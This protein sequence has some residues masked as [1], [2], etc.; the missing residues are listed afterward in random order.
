MERPGMKRLSA[1]HLDFA[2][3]PTFLPRWS[4]ALLSAGLLASTTVALNYQAAIDD[5]AALELQRARLE[6]RSASAGAGTATAQHQFTAPAA[7]AARQ[8]RQPWDTLLRDLEGAVGESDEALAL[9][10]IEPD[11][12]Q[13]QL[14]ITGEARQLG[15]ILAFVGR[16]EGAP[17]LQHPTLTGHQSRQSDG[18]PV[19]AFTILAGWKE[20]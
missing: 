6:R 5:L 15:D 14:R 20:G 10:S 16:L 2:A 17:S 13:R 3:Q 11:S 1:L 4:V 7:E 19:V 9:L 12:A 18:E 8:L